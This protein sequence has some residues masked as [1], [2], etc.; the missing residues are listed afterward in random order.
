MSETPGAHSSKIQFHQRNPS[1]ASDKTAGLVLLAGERVQS[2]SG[3]S[4]FSRSLNLNKKFESVFSSWDGRSTGRLVWR[5]C[6]AWVCLMA[7]CNETPNPSLIL[8]GGVQ[9]CEVDCCY[10]SIYVV[11]QA[12]KVARRKMKYVA[13]SVLLTVCSK[14]QKY[15]NGG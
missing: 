9:T 15:D 11:S 12:A 1:S 4:E 10:R 13:G 6:D 5:Q 8:C 7:D 14:K 3:M 2:R